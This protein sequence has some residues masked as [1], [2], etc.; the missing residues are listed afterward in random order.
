MLS[1]GVNLQADIRGADVPTTIQ[2]VEHFR[3]ESNA[4][5]LA[6]PSLSV[7]I[8]NDFLNLAVAP[9]FGSP[10][11]FFGSDARKNGRT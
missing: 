1:P 10:A 3:R 9:R 6:F 7:R 2:L 11:A 8:F 4:Q 5:G